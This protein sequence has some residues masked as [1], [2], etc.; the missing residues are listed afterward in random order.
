MDLVDKTLKKNNE[1]VEYIISG[2]YRDAK[3]ELRTAIINLQEFYQ[4]GC[5][6]ADSFRVPSFI[7][8]T[9]NIPHSRISS[10]RFIFGNVLLTSIDPN[11]SSRNRQQGIHDLTAILVFNLSI[12]YHCSAIYNASVQHLER[13]VRLY[14]KV[15]VALQ[16]DTVYF[17]TIAL[18]VFNNM[19]VIYHDLRKY[20]QARICFRAVKKMTSSKI[21]NR[22]L[23]L[24]PEACAGITSNLLF[25]K[26]PI[27]AGAA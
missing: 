25:L 22:T 10:D 13:V 26:A 1:G 14:R 21:I 11:A 6:S 12:V 5:L 9:R 19:G 3:R 16:Q 27:V 8:E 2:R 24:Q 20:A 7:I 23:V 4:N 18:S 15:L 17:H